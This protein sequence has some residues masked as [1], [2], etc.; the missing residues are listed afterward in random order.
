MT[1]VVKPERSQ[2]GGATMPAEGF[3]DPVWFPRRGPLVVAEHEAVLSDHRGTDAT[4]MV[5]ERSDRV[6]VDVD[7]VSAFGLGVGEHGTIGPSTHPH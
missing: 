1:Q 7:N 4:A 3:G 5:R 2:S 6:A